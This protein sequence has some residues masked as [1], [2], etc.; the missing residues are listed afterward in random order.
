MY[1]FLK[2]LLDILI[3]L[4][5]LA[6]VS[7]LFIIIIPLLKL[8]GE[9]E[10]FYFQK[11]MGYK[12]VPFQI[13]KFA[14]MLKNSPNMGTGTITLRNDPRVTPV[15]KF[16]R[17]T[18]INELPQLFNVLLGDMSVVGPR[19]L[20]IKDFEH[21]PESVKPIIY[22]SKPG[23]TGIGSIVFR[24]EQD[25]VSRA[26]ISPV[27]FYKRFIIPYKGQLEVWYQEH[28]SILTDILLMFLTAW[29]II[30]P[31]SML[32]YKIFKDLPERPAPLDPNIQGTI[33]VSE[34]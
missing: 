22:Q 18:K 11:R 31:K 12:N 5:A 29:V 9:G 2:R 21:Y 19:P 13:W 34:A 14:T 23:I 10:V 32:V 6:I 17:M 4:V 1:L 27:E 28:A 25:Y 33:H 26:D 7:P 20:M 30:F 8:T 15:G 16:L 3:S 24:D